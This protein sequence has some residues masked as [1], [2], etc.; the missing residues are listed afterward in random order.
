VLRLRRIKL[1]SSP[2]ADHLSNLEDTVSLNGVDG[3]ALPL[4]RG[5]ELLPE[6]RVLGVVEELRVWWWVESEKKRV[7][8]GRRGKRAEAKWRPTERG[9]EGARGDGGIGDGEGMAARVRK[10]DRGKG[11]REDVETRVSSSASGSTARAPKSRTGIGELGHGR[12]RHLLSDVDLLDELLGDGSLLMMKSESLTSGERRG[13]NGVFCEG[14]EV[15][16]SA[17]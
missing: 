3:H 11:A 15:T 17:L 6:G 5:V 1:D 8:G 9:S 16:R 14:G 2:P 4:A 12:R 10:S 7:E 13:S